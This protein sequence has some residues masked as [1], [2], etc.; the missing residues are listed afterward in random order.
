MAGRMR[1]VQ[2]DITTQAVD[3]IVNAANAKLQRGGGVDG[4]IHRAAG[5]E[6]QAAC[7]RME[8]KLELEVPKQ[9]TSAVAEMQKRGLKVVPVSATNA[10]HFRSTAEEFATSLS[11][12]RI[13]PDVLA[14]ARKERDAFRA[15]HPAK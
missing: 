5:P 6:L 4:A 9:D 7:D 11:G 14:L 1:V 8:K 10:A 12:I 3:A 13:P 2:G 15:K